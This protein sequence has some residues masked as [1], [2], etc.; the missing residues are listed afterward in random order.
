MDTTYQKNISSFK[1]D[2]IEL[3]AVHSPIKKRFYCIL[4]VTVVLALASI[5]LL[6]EQSTY[7]GC[8]ELHATIEVVGSL[9]G[10]VAGIALILHN[11]ITSNT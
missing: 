11:P 9:I 10:L 6:L 1:E 4:L 5:Y 8:H 3:F 7:K 2:N